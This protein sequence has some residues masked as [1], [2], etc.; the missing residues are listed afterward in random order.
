MYS[1][2]P[3]DVLLMCIFQVS[4][5]KK[6]VIELYESINRTDICLEGISIIYYKLWKIILNGDEFGEKT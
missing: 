3:T 4:R 1:C 6:M 5:H 2:N